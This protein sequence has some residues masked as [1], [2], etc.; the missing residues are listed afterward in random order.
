V[1]V[2]ARRARLAAGLAAL[3]LACGREPPLLGEWAVD[4]EATAP[5]VL[6]LL[7]HTGDERI[8][9]ERD[10]VRLGPT[11]LPVRYEVESDRVRLIRSD[12]DA[13]HLVELLEH[14]RIRVHYPLGYSAVYR[15]VEERGPR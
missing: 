10:R 11:V 3:A 5:G 1:R 4:P 12:R 13:E 9:F 8:V 14:G 2:A 7:R 15:R 6:A